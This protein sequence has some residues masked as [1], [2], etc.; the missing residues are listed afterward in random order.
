MLDALAIA[1]EWR[2]PEKLVNRRIEGVMRLP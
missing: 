2:S 1:S